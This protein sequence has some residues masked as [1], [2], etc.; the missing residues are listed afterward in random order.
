[1][2][3]VSRLS[4]STPSSRH[5]PYTLPQPRPSPQQ[6][7][8]D[9]VTQPSVSTD[10]YVHPPWN[11]SPFHPANTNGHFA[12]SLVGPISFDHWSAAYHSESHHHQ[13]HHMTTSMSPE[14]NNGGYNNENNLFSN[15][16][17]NPQYY[18]DHYSY[19]N[20][21][22]YNGN[23]ESGASLALPTPPNDLTHNQSSEIQQ[24]QVKL[25]PETSEQSNDDGKGGN[26]SRSNSEAWSPLTPPQMLGAQQ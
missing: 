10:G 7:I 22:M 2:V 25:E 15:P 20:G 16:Y 8:K 21:Q 12:S 5:S 19:N 13:Q 1:M 6:F 18:T 24:Q 26:E 11:A 9:D 4:K 3:D 17:Y 14:L 23:V